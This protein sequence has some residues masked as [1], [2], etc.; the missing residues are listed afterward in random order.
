MIFEEISPG[1]IQADAEGALKFCASDLWRERRIGGVIN[2]RMEADPVYHAELQYLKLPM[3]D[4]MDVP[5]AWFDQAVTFQKRL[6]E[7]NLKTVVHCAGAINRSSIIVVA[8]LCAWG[9]DPQDVIQR[10]P[11]KPFGNPTIASMLTWA[12]T[13]AV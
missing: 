6:S 10:L 2:C 7:Q 3:L 8:L 12:K 13:R 1:I 5:A 9:A 11:R 4:D